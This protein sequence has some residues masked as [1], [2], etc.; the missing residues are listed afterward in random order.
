MDPKEFC[1]DNKKWKN[2]GE[3]ILDQ[4]QLHFCENMVDVSN[5]LYFPLCYLMAVLYAVLFAITISGQIKEDFKYFILNSIIFNLLFSLYLIIYM[6][7]LR[8]KFELDDPNVIVTEIFYK[9][10]NELAIF[11]VFPTSVN[12]F[13][14]MFFT[15]FYKRTFHTRFLIS[16]II[17]FDVILVLIGFLSR[18]FEKLY[19]YIFFLTCLLLLTI[20]FSV[21]IFLKIRQQTKLLN[22]NSNT[23]IDAKRASLYI[24]F[25]ALIAFINMM[26]NTF[27]VI[28]MMYFKNNESLF[29]FFIYIY[30]F[31]IAVLD[32][33]CLVVMVLDG[34]ITLVVLKTYKKVLVQ[35]IGNVLLMIEK[36]FKRQVNPVMP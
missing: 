23:L 19:F 1:I 6:L 3:L 33:I 17:I 15:D 22:S 8:S 9:Y 32:D 16:F 27:T 30:L 14:Y 34:L 10:V 13:F 24:L 31:V 12:R 26:L 25:L 2:F 35:F 28:F 11:S 36:N 4:N 18:H 21:L 29:E 7:F 20:L 5:F